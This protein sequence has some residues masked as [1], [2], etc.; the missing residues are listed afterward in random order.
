MYGAPPKPTSGVV[1]SSATTSAHRL[2]DR[3]E[4]LGLDRPQLQDVRGRA[5]RLVEHRA[6]PWD[7]PHRDPGEQ[8][9]HDD[10]A[11]EHRRVHA[12][13]THRLEGDLGREGGVEAGVEH[14][15]AHPAR[16]VFRAATVPACRMNQIGRTSGRSPRAA[17]TS[18]AERGA[19]VEERMGLGQGADGE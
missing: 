7:D 14:L 10:V 12:V 3:R 13:A 19:A 5:H 11:E 18:G 6:A 17:R 16:P 1:P 2:A 4:R 15:G 8:H 9:R